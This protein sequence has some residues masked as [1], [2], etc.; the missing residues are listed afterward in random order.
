[1]TATRVT[2]VVRRWLTED[3]H[4]N[5]ECVL[6]SADGRSGKGFATRAVHGSNADSAAYEEAF[7]ALTRV[8]E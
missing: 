5:V 2:R 4:G 3:A 1:M 8:A 6:T 7:D